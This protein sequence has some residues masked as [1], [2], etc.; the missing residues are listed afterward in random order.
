VL[1]LEASNDLPAPGHAD[2]ERV[3]QSATVMPERSV[4]MRSASV[5]RSL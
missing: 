5:S 1:D 2:A 3:A 4:T